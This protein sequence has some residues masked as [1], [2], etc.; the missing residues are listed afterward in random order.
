MTFDANDVD[1]D[2]FE[3]RPSTFPPPMSLVNHH[4][5]TTTTTPMS[6]PTTTGTKTVLWVRVQSTHHGETTVS[7]ADV[8]R[9]AFS[10]Q[11]HA[12]TGQED[13]SLKSQIFACS[14]ERLLLNPASVG[15]DGVVTVM[16]KEDDDPSS[17]WQ[18]HNRVT[19][20]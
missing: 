7:A 3:I 9:H 10:T 5:D 1:T 8:A 17:A 6:S 2:A 20:A 11:H 15:T 4:H 12:W 18:F 13:V 19:Q 16:V 14:Q